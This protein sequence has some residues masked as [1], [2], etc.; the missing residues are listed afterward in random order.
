MTIIFARQQ[1]TVWLCAGMAGT[2]L[3]PLPLCTAPLTS[4]SHGT[5]AAIEVGLL[6]AT[7]TSK[8]KISCNQFEW[9]YLV[10]FYL[11]AWG[12]NNIFSKLRLWQYPA[13][14]RCPQR[15]P[16]TPQSRVIK[17]YISIGPSPSQASTAQP[18]TAGPE[19][20]S[21]HL[22]FWFYTWP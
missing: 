15:A 4:S 7:S 16:D 2:M 5:T 13:C 3:Q 9:L 18:S 8:Q 14:P 21:W 22:P 17:Q 12:C 6:P 20:I 1:C 11:S 19:L 10:T